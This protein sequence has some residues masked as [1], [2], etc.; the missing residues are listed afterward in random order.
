MSWA[1]LYLNSTKIIRRQNKSIWI[2]NLRQHSNPK[3]ETRSFRNSV[4]AYL[5]ARDKH[6][7]TLTEI[8]VDMERWNQYWDTFVERMVKQEKERKEEEVRWAKTV[9]RLKYE[10]PLYTTANE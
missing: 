7:K 5:L 9:K 8:Q 10:K 6:E 1:R 3:I 4:L 2:G